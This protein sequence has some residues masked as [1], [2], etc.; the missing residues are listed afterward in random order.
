MG[1][2]INIESIRA[3]EK[4]IEEGRGDTIKLKR[5]RNSLL[6]ISTRIPPEILGYILIWVVGWR[7]R[8]YSPESETHFVGLEKASY[9][10]LLVCHH[11]FEVASN[12][13]ELWSFWGN[14]LQGWNER[15]HRS[16]AAPVDLVLKGNACYREV[17]SGPLQ[18]ALRDRAT[19][20]KI[21]QI[22]LLGNDTNLLA[23]ILSSLTPDRESVQEK[24]I[25]SIILHMQTIP[26]ISP[27][28]AGSLL[29][30]L[31]YLHIG[32]ILPAP[33]WDHIT[34]QTAGITCLTTLSL[35]LSRVPLS[36]TTPQLISILLS[37][38]NL[39]ELKLS[40]VGPPCDVSRSGVRLP[41][42]RLETIALEGI[43]RR[44]FGLLNLL[45]LPSTLDCATFS[46][47][48]PTVDDILQTLVPYMRDHIRR[49][50]R[51]QDRLTIHSRCGSVDIGA[52]HNVGHARQT[53]WLAWVWQ[54]TWFT[55]FFSG[56]PY[57][58]V[59][60]LTLDLM[61]LIPYEH[62]VSLGTDWSLAI[63]EEMFIAMPNIEML[64]L[65]GAT[66]SVGFLLPNPD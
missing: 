59:R 55:A 57:P 18:N 54:P 16:G 7:E 30:K 51:F 6:N 2:E 5:A 41:L 22:H 49:D 42:R 12:T 65:T 1:R 60:G 56:P 17:L 21:R 3:L 39:R 32:G 29:P 58:I 4:Q 46:M 25:E 52:H 33:S 62:V 66:L 26:E 63:P 23:S 64:S 14:T 36:P 40:G 13:P 10:F 38:P 8:D 47:E 31:R 24:R 50:V 45:E 37:N 11:W 48:E 28:F 34:S 43:F 20:D 35:Q 15:Y 44:V 53:S 19:R 9:N 27:F 61:V